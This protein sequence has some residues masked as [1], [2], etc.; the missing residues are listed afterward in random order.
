MAHL[1]LKYTS[2]LLDIHCLNRFDLGSLVADILFCLRLPHL[3]LANLASSF[4]ILLDLFELYEC[5][6]P[7]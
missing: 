3:V 1:V 6:D 2:R 5:P 7:L 4:L